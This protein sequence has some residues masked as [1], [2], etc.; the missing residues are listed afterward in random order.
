MFRSPR[1]N[2]LP[3][4]DRKILHALVDA[5]LS[6]GLHK[7]LELLFV[8][9]LFLLWL[10]GGFFHRATHPDGTVSL[11][12]YACKTRQELKNRCGELCHAL[13][14]WQMIAMTL[15]V[16]GRDDLSSEERDKLDR[17]IDAYR[18]DDD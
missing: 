3:E 14:D 15:S 7:P 10:C 5:Q 11:D 2:D 6:S 4:L 1:R 16:K 18:D 12:P 17:L 9:P 13:S 8:T